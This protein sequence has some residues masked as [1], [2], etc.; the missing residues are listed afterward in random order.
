[1][2]T[3]FKQYALTIALVATLAITAWTA[4]Q[5]EHLDELVL[6]QP[7]KQHIASPIQPLTNIKYSWREDTPLIITRDLFPPVENQ[8]PQIDQAETAPININPF[9]Y[10]GKIVE[11][12][13]VTVFLT[14]GEKNHAVKKG[15]V[16]EQLWKIK[17]IS[18]PS[19]ILKN[20]DTK[21][22]VQ[23]EIGVIS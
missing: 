17:S 20:L 15:D 10:A 4:I 12:G 19:M 9:I 13:V 14:E 1:M 2:S 22:E 18:P 21:T 8:A 3:F 16:I 6:I 11:G 23:I 5:D 7:R